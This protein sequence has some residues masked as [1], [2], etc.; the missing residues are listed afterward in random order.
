MFPRILLGL[1]GWS[2]PLISYAGGSDAEVASVWLLDTFLMAVAGMV[3]LVIAG[4]AIWCL[5]WLRLASLPSMMVI[6]SLPFFTG[7][8]SGE[9]QR[10]ST[11]KPTLLAVYPLRHCFDFI[12]YPYVF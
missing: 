7:F 9:V 1:I 10:L 12:Y 4:F 6:V 2:W 5:V 8:I 11:I 3:R